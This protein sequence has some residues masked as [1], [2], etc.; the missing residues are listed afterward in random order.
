MEEESDK[1]LER[2]KLLRRALPEMRVADS[3][4]T[5]TSRSICLSSA[6]RRRRLES[7]GR[8]VVL[9]LMPIDSA[10]NS[11]TEAGPFPTAGNGVVHAAATP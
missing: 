6:T 10:F 1:P 5:P 4:R 9:Q 2:G 11:T 7:L 8:C 3:S